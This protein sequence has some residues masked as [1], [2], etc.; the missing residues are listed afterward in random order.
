MAQFAAE[1]MKICNWI[2]TYIS[3]WKLEWQTWSTCSPWVSTGAWTMRIQNTLWLR[4]DSVFNAVL[5]TFLLF[6]P[7]PHNS[8]AWWPTSEARHT[9]QVTKKGACWW[10]VNKQV[11]L[12]SLLTYTSVTSRRTFS[13]LSHWNH[14][15]QNLHSTNQESSYSVTFWNLFFIFNQWSASLCL[16]CF[17]AVGWAAGRASGL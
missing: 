12:H 1:K 13:K 11:N 17:D 7:T 3:A 2:Y 14:M 15:V 10:R 16:Q 8:G 5:A 4:L 6:W 9:R